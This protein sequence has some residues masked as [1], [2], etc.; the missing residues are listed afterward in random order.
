MADMIKK[1]L[2]VSFLVILASCRSAPVEQTGEAVIEQ[3]TAVINPEPVKGRVDVYESMARSVKY[4]TGATLRELRKKVVYDKNT[5]PRSIVNN[6]LKMK[7]LNQNPL[8]DSLRA[9]DFAIIYA[10]VNLSDDEHF[11]SAYL[12]AKASQTAALA[13]IKAHKDALFAQRKIKEIERMVKREQ[14]EV[15]TLKAKQDRLG[16]LNSDDEAYKKGLEVVIYKLSEIKKKLEEEVVLYRQVTRIDSDKLTLEGRRFYEMD[17]LDAGLK[18]GDFQASAFANRQEF[19]LADELNRQYSYE[20][21][22]TMLRHEYPQVERLE[23][24]GFDIEDP[25]YL[26]ELQ[27]RAD[28]QSN[29][30]ADKVRQYM[31][32]GNGGARRALRQEAFEEMATAIM[33]QN[34]VAYNVV[35]R[36]DLDDEAV[37]KRIA[38][39]KKTIAEG[40]KRYRPG[41]NQKI[42]LL[43]QKTALINLERQASQILAEKAMAIR[44]L[45]FYAGFNPFT[46][47]LTEAPV[48]DI[49]G[50]LKVGFNKDVVEMLAK[51]VPQPET[52]LKTEKNDWAKQDNWLE[53]LLEG[54]DKP[55]SESVNIRRY[56][57]NFELY[58][59]AVYNKRKIMQLGSYRQKENADMDWKMLKELYPELRAYSPVVEKAQVKGAPMYRLIIRQENGGLM[60]LCNKLR[61]DKTDCLLR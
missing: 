36:A 60:D 4:N 6:I 55:Q 21:V 17:D 51:K 49:S 25:V 44:A 7:N 10:A 14:R 12:N 13:A 19:N 32:A 56:V 31:E 1:V 18:A 46:P 16:V 34:E 35:M 30:L 50:N 59:G 3:E 11:T 29:Y 47:K 43:E 61:A 37:N 9:L 52:P 15:D 26:K 24:N 22:R 54:K 58:E 5:N 53:K 27:Q 41:V 57:G 28:F 39:L 2:S 42:D 38:E 23:I 40:E 45:Y 48:K 20:Q 8:Y 33:T